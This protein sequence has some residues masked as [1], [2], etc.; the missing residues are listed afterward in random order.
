VLLLGFVAYTNRRPASPLSPGALMQ[1]D[2]VKQDLPFG[3]ATITPQPAM[4]QKPSPGTQGK[5]SPSRRSA[6]QTPRA[7]PQPSTAKLK[8]PSEME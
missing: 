2:L 7:K 8:R 1:N 5:P 6:D 3:A 4:T